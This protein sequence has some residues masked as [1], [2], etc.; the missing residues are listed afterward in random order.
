MLCKYITIRM[1]ES[2]SSNLCSEL[3]RGVHILAF[4]SNDP[5]MNCDEVYSYYCDKF[6]E[7]NDRGRRWPNKSETNVDEGLE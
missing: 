2:G 5:S 7:K 4:Y 6:F 3:G 1:V